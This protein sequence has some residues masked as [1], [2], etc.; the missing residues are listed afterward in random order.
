MK[1][2]ILFAIAVIV[3]A[4]CEK[5]S[6]SNG[7]TNGTVARGSIVATVDGVTTTY[8]GTVSGVIQDSGTDIELQGATG[9]YP[10]LGAGIILDIT[11]PSLSART[12]TDTI[13]SLPYFISD[14]GIGYIDALGNSYF[15]AP[16][17]AGFSTI[18]VTSLT[19]T[20]I[21]GTFQGIVFVGADTSQAKKTVTN[22]KFNL[23]LRTL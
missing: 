14:A 2:I 16:S 20:Q 12:Y 13:A 17:S 11:G 5:T 9:T 23:S 19:S 22:G 4:S 15:D 3:F 8:N 1:K 21:Q 10:N 6:D 7:N 18:T